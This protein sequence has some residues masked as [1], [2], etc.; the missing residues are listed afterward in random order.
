MTPLIESTSYPRKPRFSSNL[1]SVNCRMGFTLIELLTAIA[2]IAVLAAI[3]I[4]MV[5]RGVEKS[6]VASGLSNLRQIGSA[7]HIY[8]VDNDGL[9]PPGYV[10][11]SETDAVVGAFSTYLSAMIRNDDRFRFSDGAKVD[12]IFKDPIAEI[13]KGNSHFS[14]HPIIMPHLSKDRTTKQQRVDSIDRPAE[15]II[16]MDGVQDSGGSAH[17]T[18]WKLGEY[19]KAYSPATA[20]TPIS[21][22]TGLPGDIRWGIDNGTK[23]KFL[24]VDGHVEVRSKEEVLQKNVRL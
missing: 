6:R 9:L 18:A 8:T 17:S 5:N 13:D 1:T 22:D 23:A 11:D 15:S 7:I 14:T 4:P 24:F 3:L 12:A 16:V 19:S 2:I 10:Q 21:S 20:N